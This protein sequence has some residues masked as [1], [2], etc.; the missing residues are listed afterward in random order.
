MPQLETRYS[1]I[2]TAD[3]EQVTDFLRDFTLQQEEAVLEVTGS[4]IAVEN[5]RF[6]SNRYDPIDRLTG[7]DIVDVSPFS[8]VVR[9]LPKT[10]ICYAGEGVTWDKQYSKNPSLTIKNA[11][12]Q[13]PHGSP[14]FNGK[15]HKQF[16]AD[17][18]PDRHDFGLTLGRAT[19][20]DAQFAGRIS[21]L[22]TAKQIDKRRRE[23]DRW[24]N[25]G[26]RRD[27][28]VHQ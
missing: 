22:P 28:A 23:E 17:F 5:F 25:V 18:D 24:R 8:I 12:I 6:N 4:R 2:V 27:P 13:L 26:R 11:G 7:S 21:L 10:K 20:D 9:S 3:A 16:N 19:P 14:S 15:K 1:A